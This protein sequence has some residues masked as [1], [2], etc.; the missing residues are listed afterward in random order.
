[1]VLAGVGVVGAHENEAPPVGRKTWR[2]VYILN[3]Q[4]WSPAQ[5]ANSVKVVLLGRWTADQLS[6]REV[7]VAAL[8]REAQGGVLH[9]LGR[10]DL[11]VAF[12]GQMAQPQGFISLAIH[13]VGQV[14]SVRRHGADSRRA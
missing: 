7:N 2:R 1:M 5:D 10:N 13:H 11:H 6:V 9:M 3:E 4:L 8:G 12:A 14:V